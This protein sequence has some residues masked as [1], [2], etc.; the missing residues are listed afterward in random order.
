MGDG[1]E[2]ESEVLNKKEIRE[3]SRCFGQGTYEVCA[4]SPH[5]RFRI[6]KSQAPSSLTFSTLL[7]FFGRV[8]D[9]SAT[10]AANNYDWKQVFGMP[11][12]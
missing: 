2:V 9:S 11:G 4:P 3:K 8:L 10:S 7:V 5:L 6:P 12:T 1:Q